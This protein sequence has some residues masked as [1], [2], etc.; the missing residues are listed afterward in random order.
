MSRTRGTVPPVR[1]GGIRGVSL[2]AVVVVMAGCGAPEKQSGPPAGE[3]VTER[4]RAEQRR[5]R[6]RLR[7]SSLP[8]D[9]QRELN[10]AQR[11]LDEAD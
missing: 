3:T 11:L 4:E 9:L 7:E 1:A 6:E 5:V 2:L 10:E 8:E